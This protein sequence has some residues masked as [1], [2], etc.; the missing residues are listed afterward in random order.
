MKKHKKLRYLVFV[1]AIIFIIG[2]VVAVY[3]NMLQRAVE[4]TTKSNIYEIASLNQNTLKEYVNI[5]WEDLDYIGKKIVSNKC[6][7]MQEAL[8]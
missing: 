8:E 1:A 2:G 5:A 4:T 3:S 6:D 7:S